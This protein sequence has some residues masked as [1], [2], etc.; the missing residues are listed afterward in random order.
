[1]KLFQMVLV[2]EK[3]GHDQSSTRVRLK[4]GIAEG[5]VDEG[6]RRACEDSGDWFPLAGKS[7]RRLPSQQTYICQRYHP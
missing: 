6:L 1:M 2:D 7:R 4:N 3:Q 5:E